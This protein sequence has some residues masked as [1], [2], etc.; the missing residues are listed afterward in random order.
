MGT[1]VVTFLDRTSALSQVEKHETRDSDLLS[2]SREKWRMETGAGGREGGEGHDGK[3]EEAASRVAPA[4]QTNHNTG[5][6]NN[7]T[8]ARTY[9]PTWACRPWAQRRA[10]P[11]PSCHRRPW[12]CLCWFVCRAGRRKGKEVSQALAIKHNQNILLLLLEARARLLW[13][14]GWPAWPARNT[15]DWERRK[16]SIG[17]RLPF[18]AMR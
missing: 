15:G 4:K 9:R 3:T 1:I 5:T 14:C 6:Q 11:S 2:K 16:N 7:Y 17:E 12:C 8:S 18:P 13:V 10:R